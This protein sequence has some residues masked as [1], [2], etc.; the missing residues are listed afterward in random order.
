MNEL[1]KLMK[2]SHWDEVLVIGLVGVFAVISYHRYLQIKETKQRI[3]LNE[4]QLANL[5]K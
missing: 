1:I 2:E 3:Q 5:T 4:I